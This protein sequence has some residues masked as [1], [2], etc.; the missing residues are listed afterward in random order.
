MDLKNIN[1][2]SIK[3]INLEDLK[4]KIQSIDKNTLIK[5]GAGF[6]AIV[7]FLIIYYGIVNP[8]AEKRKKIFE[9]MNVKIASIKKIK[10]EIIRINKNIKKNKPEFEK[11]STLFHSK[12]EVEGLYQTISQYALASGLVIT[13][14]QKQDPIPVM[15]AGKSAKKKRRS[16]RNSKKLD[17][18]KVSYYT[19]PVEFEIK[20]N[21]LG[22]IKF[23]KSMSDSIKM[24]NF[25]K[26]IISLV[27]GDSNG[28][29]IATG[30]LTVVGLPNEF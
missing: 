23:K 10:S 30:I 2:D 17:K 29:V 28:S 12:E 24:M 21:F 9:D 19:I 26:E 22:Y 5:I 8:I 15:R 7:I 18:S 13:K 11:Y 1:L 16:S 20:G 27:K 4:G 14:I 25:D 3:N 6:A